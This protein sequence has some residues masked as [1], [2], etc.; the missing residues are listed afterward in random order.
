MIND[1]LHALDLSPYIDNA[2]NTFFPQPN[3]EDEIILS[4]DEKK[5]IVDQITAVRTHLSIAKHHIDDE[6]FDKAIDEVEQAIS[7]STCGRCKKKMLIAAYDINHAS[8]VCDLDENRCTTVKT[9]I[10]KDIKEFIEN[11]LPQVEE[12]LSAR[13]R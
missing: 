12:V 13:E 2:W 11:Y 8:N 1:V 7:A 6:N 9:D 5:L 3:N 10:N 4:P